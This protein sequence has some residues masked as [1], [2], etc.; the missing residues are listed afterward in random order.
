V[1]RSRVAAAPASSYLPKDYWE[2]VARRLS[3][4]EQFRLLA[5]EE[6]PF[7]AIKR[8]MLLARMLLPA[9]ADLEGPALEI[10]CGPGGNLSQLQ[11][12]GKAVAGLDLSTT[13]LREASSNGLT[14][15]VNGNATMLPFRSGTMAAVY[16]VTVLQHNDDGS[17]ARMLGEMARVSSSEVHLFEDTGVVGVHD[18]PSHWVRT[19][20][21]YANRLS[22]HGYR[23]ENRE[24]IPLAFS[25]IGANVIRAVA[26][27]GRPEGAAL[28]ERRVRL[29]E[30][31]LQLTLRVDRVVPPVVGLTRLSFRRRE[32]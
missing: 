12:L 5:G 30:R 24:R 18:R 1:K 26:D 31:A 22:Q 9:L 4:R 8:E 3:G 6:S 21:W 23:L 17:A 14:R 13:M 7:Y 28:S 16:T 19:P 20:E 10:G 29:E 27:R 25:E 11:D 32:T 15:L 2:G